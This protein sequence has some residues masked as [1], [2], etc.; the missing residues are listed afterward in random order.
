MV[1]QQERAYAQAVQAAG[2]AGLLRQAFVHR[3]GHCTF[4]PA[5]RIAAVQA[6]LHRVETGA[7]DDAATPERLNPAAAALGPALNTLLLSPT[8]QVPTPAAFQG[9]TPG[10]YLRPFNLPPFVANVA[11]PLRLDTA[12]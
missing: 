9:Y 11:D 5:E 1:V 7:W 6:L 2:D 8:V 12:A 3:A 10:P 4:T